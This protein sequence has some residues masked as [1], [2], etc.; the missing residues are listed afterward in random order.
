MGD[1]GD[2]ESQ[3]GVEGVA[4]ERAHVVEETQE[5]CESIAGLGEPGEVHTNLDTVTFDKSQKHIVLGRKV[6]EEIARAHAC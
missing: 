3:A 1:R 5:R 4:C 6:V 2:L